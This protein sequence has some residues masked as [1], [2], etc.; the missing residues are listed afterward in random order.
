[1][2]RLTTNAVSTERYRA[3]VTIRVAPSMRADLERLAAQEER[4]VAAVA[5]RALR[6]AIE[7]TSPPKRRHRKA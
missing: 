1:V 5:R 4:S 3:V 2:Q 7:E 6:A